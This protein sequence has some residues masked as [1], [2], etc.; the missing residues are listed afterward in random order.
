[1]SENTSSSEHDR[2][3]P[4][5]QFKLSE[6]RKQGQVAKSLDINSLFMVFFLLC[7]LLLLGGKAWQQMGMFSENT[8]IGSSAYAYDQRS[9]VGALTQAAGTF[10]A[11]I[12]TPLCF[13]VA[14]AVLGNL[15]QT[16]PIF[17]AAPL[18]PKFER[19]N[20]VAGFKRVFNKRML[21]EAL[22]SMIKLVIL[23]AVA[24]VTFSGHW[25]ELSVVG[26]MS[27]AEQLSWFVGLAVV[28]LFRLVMAMVVI[29]LLDL[30]LTR[31]QF[32]K[33]MRMSR[34]DMKEEVK[35]REGDPLIRSK[36]RQLQKENLKQSKSLSRVSD[37]DVL[38]TNPTHLA[39]ALRYVRGEMSAPNVIAKG[40][41]RW[42]KDMRELAGRYG[43][44]VF[45]RKSLA[46][47][48]FRKGQLDHPVP[49]DTFID[50]ARLYADLGEYQRARANRGEVHA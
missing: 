46:R 44:P 8:F 22:K 13:G 2:T 24:Y 9:V 1:M 14:G 40:S 19:I 18:K 37:A 23:L 50:V 45:E 26:P 36:I 32:S 6:A 30:A 42:A 27:A 15:I 34:L 3:E 28:L 35:R 21:F 10:W 17:S 25:Q 43:V 4:A 33:Q 12:L 39:V 48:L 31:W 5:S 29:A 16:G 7:A 49:V 11:V 38:I 41:E 20:P 47:A